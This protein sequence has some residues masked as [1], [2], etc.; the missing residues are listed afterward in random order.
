MPIKSASPWPAASIITCGV[1]WSDAGCT[2]DADAHAGEQVACSVGRVDCGRTHRGMGGERH[3]PPAVAKKPDIVRRRVSSISRTLSSPL[4][5]TRTVDRHPT[6]RLALSDGET[7]PEGECNMTFP[8]LLTAWAASAP[9][10][11][12]MMDNRPLPI[13]RPSS[14]LPPAGTRP[15]SSEGTSPAWF[16][17]PHGFVKPIVRQTSGCQWPTWAAAGA[18]PVTRRCGVGRVRCAIPDVAM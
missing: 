14:A 15:G 13:R 16:L 11:S 7:I 9:H 18:R 8:L 2:D 10:T 17:W 3:D 1:G 6:I 5:A 4:A 12:N